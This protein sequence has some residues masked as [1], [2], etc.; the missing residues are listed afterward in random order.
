[1]NGAQVRAVPQLARQ[2][3]SEVV[4][5]GGYSIAR[6]YLDGRT[7]CYPVIP[8]ACHS[9]IASRKR[10]HPCVAAVGPRTGHRLYKLMSRPEH[11]RMKP[12]RKRHLG[13]QGQY[14][15]SNS[16][17]IWIK[18]RSFNRQHRREDSWSLERSGLTGLAV[19][20]DP[21]QTG[22]RLLYI[23]KFWL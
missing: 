18:S 8:V 22:N 13:W 10:P 7:I 3:C 23:S 4:F 1:M 2:I 16:R 11:W 14:C 5:S 6:W 17:F 20:L 19:S 12:L 15:S 21:Q 9:L